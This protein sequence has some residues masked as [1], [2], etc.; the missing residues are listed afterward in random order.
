MKTNTPFYNWLVEQ[1]LEDVN[2]KEK[3]KQYHSYFR[4]LYRKTYN[5]KHNPDRK[6]SHVSFNE[7]DF[8]QLRARADQVGLPVATFIRKAAMS[9]VEGRQSEAS[10]MLNG[11]YQQLGICL[12]DLEFVAETKIGADSGI[13]EELRSRLLSIEATLKESFKPTLRKGSLPVKVSSS[14][15][16]Y[17]S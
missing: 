11:I 5:E 10:S 4:K 1:G 2:D 17:S 12:S 14:S 6:R 15:L 16:A 3:R 9:A 13:Y 7:G 8:L